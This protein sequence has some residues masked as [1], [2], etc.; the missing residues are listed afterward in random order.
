M[1]T[2]LDLADDALLLAKRVA[3]RERLSLVDAVSRLVLAGAGVR[4][5]PAVQSRPP[6]LRGRFELLPQRDE[7]ITPAHVRELMGNEAL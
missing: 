4:A 1:R 6:S 2:T 3:A 7:V 5:H